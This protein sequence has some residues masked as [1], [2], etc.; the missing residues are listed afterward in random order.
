MMADFQTQYKITSYK[1]KTP[2][3]KIPVFTYRDLYRETAPL[4]FTS[5]QVQGKVSQLCHV[6]FYYIRNQYKQ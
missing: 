6:T 4:I 5:P 1:Y 3:K 2:E